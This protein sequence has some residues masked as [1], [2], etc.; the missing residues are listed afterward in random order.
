VKL[1]EPAQRAILRKHNPNYPASE[2]NAKNSFAR[3]AR[4]RAAA[5]RPGK[6]CS[7][8]S[9]KLHLRVH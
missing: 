9:L 6:K 4:E 7:C 5:L 3:L 1:F 8:K 2:T